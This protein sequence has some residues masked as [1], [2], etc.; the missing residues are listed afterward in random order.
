MENVLLKGVNMG[1]A[2][3]GHFP[4]ETAITKEEY[5]RW[6][7]QIGAMHANAVRVYTIHP[8]AFYEAFYEYNEIAEQPLYL[9]LYFTGYG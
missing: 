6:F 7:K 5:F 8:P 9:F 1:I 4:G 3:P 2:K